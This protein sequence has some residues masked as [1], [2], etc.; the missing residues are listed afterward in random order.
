MA[1]LNMGE[2]IRIKNVSPFPVGFCRINSGGEV[3]IPPNTSISVDRGE[4]V[5]QVQ[6]GSILFNG[7]GFDNSHAYLYIEDEETRKYVGFDT[8]DKK[9]EVFDVGKIEELF[10]IKTLSAF[11][12][13]VTE[14]VTTLAEKKVL[15]D[16]LKTLDIND[17]AK[18]KFVEEITGMEV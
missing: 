14:T 16:K 4:I 12:K 17:H 10:K 6:S 18:I 5:S 3:N 9:Q 7:E 2:L 11:K 1:N 15:V 13:A 8:E